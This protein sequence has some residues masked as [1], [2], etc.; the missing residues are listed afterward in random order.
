VTGAGSGIGKAAAQLYAAEGAQV[1]CADI[2]GD[3]AAATAAEIGDAAISMRVDVTQPDDCQAMTSQAVA[4]F[5]GLDA[6]YSNAGV[7]GPGRAGDLSLEEWNRVIGVNLTGKWL[8][9]KYAIPHLVEAGGGSLVLQA[10]VGGVIG[11]PGIAAYS[12]AKAGVIGLTRQMAVDYGPDNIRVNAICPGTVPTPL[13][14]ATYEK[15]GGFSATAAADASVD[16]MIE[17]AVVR[18]PIGRLGTTEDI[19]QLALHLASDES[20][21]T[22]GTAIVIDGGMSVA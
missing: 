14:R 19:A 1:M 8:S 22:T 3:A 16:E 5:G 4:A 11:V 2:N 10:S 12:A 9:V 17:A 13:V 6:V 21:W 18:H 15:R 7:D 20:S